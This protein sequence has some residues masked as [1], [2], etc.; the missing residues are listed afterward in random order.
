[1]DLQRQLASVNK[2]IQRLQLM[3]PTTRR[4]VNDNAGAATG[5]AA[6]QQGRP[7]VQLSKRPKGRDLYSLWTEYTHGLGG[8]K[9]AKEFTPVERGV[10]LKQKYYRRKAF[11]DAVATHVDAGYTAPVAVDLVYQAYGRSLSVSRPW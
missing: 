10:V 7:N 3:A 9:A 6:P 8:L 11:W 2:N 1:M 5:A 4:G